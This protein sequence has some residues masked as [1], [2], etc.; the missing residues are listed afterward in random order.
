MP[1]PDLLQHLFAAAIAS[2]Q[3]GAVRAAL[4]APA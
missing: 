4:F 2:A 3:P 1:P